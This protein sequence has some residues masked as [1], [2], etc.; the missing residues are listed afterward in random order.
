[1]A[2]SEAIPCPT[3]LSKSQETSACSST[4]Q[5][6]VCEHT[7]V[8]VAGCWDVQPIWVRFACIS[9]NHEKP[10]DAFVVTDTQGRHSLYL[11]PADGTPTARHA[12]TVAVQIIQVLLPVLKAHHL[13][14]D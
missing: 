3:V 12:L 7:N 11:R 10:G 8:P 5:A 13:G 1:M 14:A 2:P 9:R 4:T 6:H